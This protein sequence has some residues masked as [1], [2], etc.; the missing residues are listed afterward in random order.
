VETWAGWARVCALA[1]LAVA[2]IGGRAHAHF[3]KTDAAD[4]SFA[5]RQLCYSIS[6]PVKQDP[7]WAGWIAQ[8]AANWNAVS[9]QTGWSFHECADGEAGDISIGFASGGPSDSAAGSFMG[10]AGASQHEGQS[11]KPSHYDLNVVQ[12]VSGKTINE[13]KIG[14][15]GDQGWDTSGTTSLDPVLVLMHELTH[16][17]RLSHGPSEGWNKNAV[18]APF[19]FEAPVGPGIHSGTISAD[20]ITQTHTAASDGKPAANF[21]YPLPPCF[22]DEAARE[23]AS[24]DLT[25]IIAQFQETI[26]TASAALVGQH[27]PAQV[28]GLYAQAKQ[29]VSNLEAARDELKSLP[30]ICAA[31]DGKT[32]TPVP[33]GA[34]KPDANSHGMRTP[35][36]SREGALAAAVIDELNSARSD[37][38]G[39]A[40]KLGGGSAS[41]EAVAFLKQE[42]P[43]PPLALIPGLAAAAIRHAAD[44]GPR[45]LAG[46]IGSD[47]STLAQRFG[48][49]GVIAGISAEEISVG[50]A[51]AGGVVRQLIIDA[52]SPSRRHRR[53]VF[54]AALRF[55]G[56]GCGPHATFSEIC[57]IDLAGAL[58]G[59]AGAGD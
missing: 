28:A 13:V 23:K 46:H 5:E 56:V 4:Y 29:A 22:A 15:G 12:D 44:Q 33:S 6:P 9:S 10:D 19:N 18:G 25:K 48:S 55:V 38:A 34:E 30:G 45:G 27:D 11:L 8:A 50:Q 40:N 57:V 20:D 37:P 43:V 31:G 7:K 16:A 59:G 26:G 2:T 51:T 58:M 24:S 36:A 49:A 52:T 41:A 53:D 32:T 21:H 35:S 39:Y 14:N 42:A 1:A 54:D 3:D 17:M 47:G